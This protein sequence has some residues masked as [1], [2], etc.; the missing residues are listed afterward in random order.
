MN[1]RVNF[2]KLLTALIDYLIARDEGYQLWQSYMGE[3]LTYLEYKKHSARMAQLIA[4]HD[5]DYCKAYYAEDEMP[6]LEQL[7][8]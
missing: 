4:K 5:G 6:S 8:A 3:R 1:I 7:L 2:V